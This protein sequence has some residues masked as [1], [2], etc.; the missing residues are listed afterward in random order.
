MRDLV[1]RLSHDGITILLSSHVL[2]EVED[3]CNRVAI[4]RRGTILYEGAL[5]ELLLTSS[6]NYRLRTREPERART[7][8]LN[9]PGIRDLRQE[10]D[11]L[12]FSA[13]EDSVATLSIALGQSRVAITELAAQNA[14]LEELFLGMTGGESSDHDRQAIAS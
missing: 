7:I 9:Q 8:C 6:S 3:L 1:R 13:D 11:E 4:I 5:A 2:H 14:S 12:R 10:G